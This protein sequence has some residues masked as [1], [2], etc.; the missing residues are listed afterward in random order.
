MSIP[1]ELKEIT[2]HGESIGQLP[3]PGHTSVWTLGAG[4]VTIT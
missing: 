4:Q 1:G 2:A 3:L